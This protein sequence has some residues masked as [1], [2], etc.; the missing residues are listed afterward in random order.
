MHTS[1][2]KKIV[3][4]VLGLSL[5]IGLGFVVGLSSK[6]SRY[7]EPIPTNSAW[8]MP[9]SMINPKNEKYTEVN[10]EG[11]VVLIVDDAENW[12]VEIVDKSLLEFIPGGDQ[13]TYETYPGLTALAAG[14]SKVTA[15]APDGTRYE[16]TVLIKE[17]GIPLWG[18]EAL[19]AEIAAAVIGKTEQEAME[20]INSKGGQIT[21]RIVKRD[22]ESFPVTMDYRMDRINLEIENGV[23]TSASVG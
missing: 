8:V 6:G 22:D 9:P 10:V 15:I 19:A 17:K 23:I 2:M 5:V 11:S 14:T 16:F 18:P 20:M 4:I 12:T 13:G 1:Y 7:P 21:Y 3:A